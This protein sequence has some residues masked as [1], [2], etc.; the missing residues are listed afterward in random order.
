[1][2]ARGRVPVSREE[3]Q[4]AIEGLQA[5]GTTVTIRAVRDYIGRGSFST[6]KA[7]MDALFAN[8]ATP[9]EHLNA[10]APRLGVLCEEMISHMRVLADETLAT[11]RA[12]FEKQRD[13]HSSKWEAVTHA[14]DLAQSQLDI[15]RRHSQEQKTRIKDLEKTLNT[16]QSEHQAS[17]QEL[18]KANAQIQSLT[19]RATQAESA[20]T[21][22]RTQQE[23]YKQE[24]ENQQR[25]KQ[26]EH[27]HAVGQLNG[28]VQ[29]LTEEGSELKVEASKWKGQF[30]TMEER[31]NR[32]NDALE[33]AKL[34]RAKLQEAHDKLQELV[35]AL[36]IQQTKDAAS[37]TKATDQLIEAHNQLTAKSN[38][39]TQLQSDML[40]MQKQADTARQST[41]EEHKGL[42]RNLI[43]HARTAFE[44]AKAATPKGSSEVEELERSQRSIE[45]LLA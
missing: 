43:A 13:E 29:A 31:L 19:A 16:S 11:E 6:I 37:L 42:I 38:T 9:A 20:L 25:R 12:H 40:N 5:A 14:R 27:E 2:G 44:M 28:K 21:N 26:Q 10:F 15:E 36:S 45:Q 24:V 35:G 7:H 3:V 41:A 23:H 22:A 32:S 8:A 34:E 1:M 17:I 18:T 39:I 30:E 4:Q 33:I